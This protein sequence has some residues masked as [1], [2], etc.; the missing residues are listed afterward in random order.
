MEKHHRLPEVCVQIM[1]GTVPLGIPGSFILHFPHPEPL[2]V[3]HATPPTTPTSL[4]AS[5]ERRRASR[6]LAAVEL[7]LTWA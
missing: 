1:E 2:H 5:L 7:L 6:R 3:L 4:M